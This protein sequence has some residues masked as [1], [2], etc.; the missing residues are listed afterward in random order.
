MKIRGHRIE[1]E[2][3]EEH[4]RRS[5]GIAEAAVIAIGDSRDVMATEPKTQLAAY[6]VAPEETFS[7]AEVKARLGGLVP[8]YMV[9]TFVINLPTLPLTPNGKVDLKRLPSPGGR[10][11]SPPPANTAP[12]SPE[13][14]AIAQ[15]WQN[16]LK[17]DH[18]GRTDN[19]FEL[20]GHSLMAMTL[21]ARL[22]KAFGRDFALAGFLQE[23]TIAGLAARLDP[24][25]SVQVV[26]SL[27]PLRPG[28]ERP[29]LILLHAH[30]GQPLHYMPLVRRLPESWPVHAFQSRALDRGK[31]DDRLEEIAARYV[32]ELRELQPRGPYFLAGQCLGGF[33]AFEMAQQLVQL[34]ESIGFLGIMEAPAPP[35]RQHLARRSPLARVGLRALT[36][37]HYEFNIHARLKR[38]EILFRYED[39]WNRIREFIAT[40][41]SAAST[42][43][44][45]S[46]DRAAFEQVAY[47]RKVYRTAITTYRPTVYPGA[48]T[49]VRS[50]TQPWGSNG[51][52]TLGWRESITGEITLLDVPG[53]STTLI[54]DPIVDVLAAK[55]TAEL[56]QA[57][58][59]L[60]GEGS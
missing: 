23:P 59:R 1:P 21:M 56:D 60:S 55:L 6:I 18:V 17:I 41:G 36:R 58:Q 20:G 19:F 15:I 8:A 25:S 3:I 13:E 9:P 54:A 34:G 38:R 47:L 40:R 52:P 48:A 35:F 43:D 37:A 7:E 2:E 51:D 11:A 5:A 45:T 53:H 39:R 30:S 33:L 14:I 44:G 46:R 24:A 10:T 31:E 4:L 26:K 28:G 50:A 32:Q 29:P 42:D 27:I 49:I 16:L 12:S 22:K 57:Y